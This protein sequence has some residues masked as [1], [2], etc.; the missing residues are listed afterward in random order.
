[1][2]RRNLL[3]RFVFASALVGGLAACGDQSTSQR[4]TQAAHAELAECSVAMRAN[5]TALEVQRTVDAV[6]SG[7][8]DPC[9]GAV[10]LKGTSA[11]LLRIEAEDRDIRMYFRVL[12]G[13]QQMP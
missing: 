6:L 10:D 7:R 8:L 2:E 4:A 9:N 12:R 3:Y 1:M 11:E 5:S 13:N